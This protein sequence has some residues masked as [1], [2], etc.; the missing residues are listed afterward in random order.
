MYPHQ[1]LMEENSLTKDSLS[2]EGKG[3]LKD[4]N[5][6]LNAIN[7]KIKRAEKKGNDIEVSA[8]EMS[9]LNRLSKS[10]VVQIYA[11]MKKEIQERE[12]EKEEEA[13]MKQESDDLKKQQE[14]EEAKILAQNEEKR[15]QE[16]IEKIIEEEKEAKEEKEKKEKEEKEEEIAN[17]QKSRTQI[18]ERVKQT[19][20]PFIPDEE[21]EESDELMDFF[22]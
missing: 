1:V 15:K 5:L 8:N 10:V 21:E 13:K 18:R 7:L 16:E 17:Q 20:E 9:K 3:Y 12:R 19:S 2:D 14:E 6:Y 11:E 4:F 22:F